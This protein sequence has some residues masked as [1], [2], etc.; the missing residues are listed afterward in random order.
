[1]DYFLTEEQ[2]MIKELARKITDERI[3]PV[4]AELDE[5]EEFPHDLI[6]VMAASDLFGISIPSRYGGLGGG[7]LENC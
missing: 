3:I 2:S 5:K 7:V 6:K 1:M 4:R